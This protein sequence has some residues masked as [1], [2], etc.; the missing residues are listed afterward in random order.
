MISCVALCSLLSVS[1]PQQIGSADRL[2]TFKRDAE[3]AIKKTVKIVSDKNIVLYGGLTDCDSDPVLIRIGTN[4][5]PEVRE[6]LLAH[7]LGHVILCGRKMFRMAP[8]SPSS[9]TLA[10]AI[11]TGLSAEIGSCYVD[12]LADAEAE[13]HGFKVRE[14]D[15]LSVEYMTHYPKSEIKSS[16]DKF[17]YYARDYSALSIYCMEVR[18]G[19]PLPELERF[20]AEQP[21]I[22]ERLTN[23]RNRMGTPTCHDEWSCYAI[24][25][26]LRDEFYWA[27]YVLMTN[28]T[29]GKV[30]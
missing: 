3:K 16:L 18:A 8:L 23:L 9:P 4:Y 20:F 1:V 29:T 11:L 10:Q 24:S 2:Y 30:E 19:R 28:P 15:A 22:L 25:R 7:E 21:E 12:P 17:S 13:K 26:Q 27:K 5:K 14:L 6:L